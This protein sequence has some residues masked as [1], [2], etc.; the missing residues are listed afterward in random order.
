MSADHTTND[1]NMDQPSADDTHHLLPPEKPTKIAEVDPVVHLRSNSTR[2]AHI[3]AQA[4]G[5]PVPFCIDQEKCVKRGTR[6][7]C[8][9]MAVYPDPAAWFA[10]ICQ[11]C[12]QAYEEVTDDGGQA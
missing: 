1:G 3:A 7:V 8:K 11:Y 9:D 6:W 2:K 5:H 4:D 10:K 12:Q